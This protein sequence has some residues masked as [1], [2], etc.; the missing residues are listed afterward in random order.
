[1]DL[2]EVGCEGDD[3]IRI[4][5]GGGLCESGHEPMGSIKCRKFL[6]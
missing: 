1:M 5:T 3:W 4:G 6:D 2:Q